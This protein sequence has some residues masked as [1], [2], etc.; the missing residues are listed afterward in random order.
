MRATA[1]ADAPVG[2]L[3]D[4]DL[5]AAARLLLEQTH[6][7]G[8]GGR[9]TPELTLL[10]AVPERGHERAA[11]AGREGEPRRQEPLGNCVEK[12]ELKRW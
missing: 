12:S 4:G 6:D 1:A 5:E 11:V 3:V 8:V 7:P 2:G 10:V 9:R